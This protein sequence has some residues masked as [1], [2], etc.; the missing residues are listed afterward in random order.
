MPKIASKK[1]IFILVSISSPREYADLVLPPVKLEK[2]E[3]EEHGLRKLAGTGD[4]SEKIRTYNYP[5]DRITDHRIGF[6]TSLK[7]IMDGELSKII[8]ALIADDKAKKITEA[9]L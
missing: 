8:D 3:S 6:S 4:R 9:G 7:V 2:R 5:Q 1:S